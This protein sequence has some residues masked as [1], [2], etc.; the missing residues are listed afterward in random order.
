MAHS[1]QVREFVITR[2]GIK[3]SD[4]IDAKGIPM[5]SSRAAQD[6][7]ERVRMAMSR[8]TAGRDRTA[9]ARKRG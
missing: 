3:L 4:G 6:A 5:E 8:G 1:N 7:S 2:H 9:T